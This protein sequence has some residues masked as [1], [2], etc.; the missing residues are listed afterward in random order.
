MFR[1]NLPPF[2]ATSKISPKATYI[3]YLT[4]TNH[5]KGKVDAVKYKW[6]MKASDKAFLKRKD[7]YYFERFSDMPALELYLRMLSASIKSDLWIG[8][9][10]SD[11]N[12]ELYF[13]YLG[14]LKKTKEIYTEDI[15]SLLYFCKSK[16]L[17]MKDVLYNKTNNYMLMLINNDIITIESYL[18]LD[19]FLGLINNYTKDDNIFWTSLVNRYECY[20]KLLDIDSAKAKETFVEIVNNSKQQ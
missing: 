1:L 17:K 20:R 8:D 14:K 6:S 19:S 2:K 13:E 11:E 7:R 18:I 10:K 9:L 5:F 4:L 16:D 15:N 3:L 12:Q